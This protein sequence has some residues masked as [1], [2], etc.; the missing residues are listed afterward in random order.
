MTILGRKAALSSDS[1]RDGSG[2]AALA[3]GVK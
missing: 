1:M 3:D 2:L